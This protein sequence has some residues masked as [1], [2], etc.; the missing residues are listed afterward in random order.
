MVAPTISPTEERGLCCPEKRSAAGAKPLQHA[1]ASTSHQ[2]K[3]EGE[4]SF[5]SP[6]AQ[7]HGATQSLVFSLRSRA[8]LTALRRSL[9]Q[10]INTIWHT[11]ASPEHPFLC[12]QLATPAPTKPSLVVTGHMDT[13]GPCPPLGWRGAPQHQHQVFQQRWGLAAFARLPRHLRTEG[14]SAPT[15]AQLFVFSYRYSH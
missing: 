8:T 12:S 7:P 1:R 4:K 9:A 5:L 14:L 11:M 2:T 6:T 10:Q 3:P 15:P 13:L